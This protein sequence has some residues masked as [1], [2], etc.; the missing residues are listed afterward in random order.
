MNVLQTG[1]LSTWIKAKNEVWFI[2]FLSV[3][4]NLKRII[5]LNISQ[6]MGGAKWLFRRTVSKGSQVQIPLAELF[7]RKYHPAS[8]HP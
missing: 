5:I 3:A 6:I 7:I 4:V 8:Q 2:Q 1:L